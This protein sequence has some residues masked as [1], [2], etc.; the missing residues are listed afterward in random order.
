MSALEQRAVEQ[1]CC[2]VI[3]VTETDRTE[4]IRFYASLGYDPDAHTGF[5]RQ[6]VRGQ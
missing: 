5:K 2:Q 4:A 3:F 6:L 1:N